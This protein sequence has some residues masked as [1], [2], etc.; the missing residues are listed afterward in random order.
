MAIE[1]KIRMDATQWTEEQWD[2]YEA[3][4]VWIPVTLL[5]KMILATEAHLLGMRISEEQKKSWKANADTALILLEQKIDR[6]VL[7]GKDGLKYE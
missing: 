5:E 3:V 4:N 6:V 1:K 2:I 7:N